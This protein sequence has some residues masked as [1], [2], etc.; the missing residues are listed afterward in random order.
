MNINKIYQKALKYQH[1][2]AM[3]LKFCLLDFNWDIN[4]RIQIKKMINALTIP[5]VNLF[6]IFII[7]KLNSCNS[8]SEGV[9]QELLDKINKVLKNNRMNKGIKLMDLINQVGKAV[10][11]CGVIIK[12]F[13]KYNINS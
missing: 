5:I 9:K 13:S 4:I 2:I 12:Q 10:D 1:I 8:N 6:D 11:N 3:Y 7:K